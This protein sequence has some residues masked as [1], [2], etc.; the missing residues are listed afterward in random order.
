MPPRREPEVQLLRFRALWNPKQ[1]SVDVSCLCYSVKVI[2]LH[3]E[4]WLSA[5]C[6]VTAWSRLVRGYSGENKQKH[7]AT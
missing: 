3:N 1:S 2:G 4:P 7:P 6:L 5:M